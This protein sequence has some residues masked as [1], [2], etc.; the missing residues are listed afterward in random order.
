MFIDSFKLTKDKNQNIYIS[1]KY[2]YQFNIPDGYEM[3]SSK[4][5]NI[6]LKI[7]NKNGSVILINISPRTTEEYGITAHDY[8]REYLAEVFRQY[9]PYHTITR[10]EKTD[11][12]NINAFLINYVDKKNATKSIEIYFYKQDY[13]IVLTATCSESDFNNEEPNLLSTLRSFCFN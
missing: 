4:N 5:K 3:E 7:F 6:D 9:A 12:D 2:N 1:K 13:A 10:A 11:I 8:T